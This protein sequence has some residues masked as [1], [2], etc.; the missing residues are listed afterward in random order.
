[1]T[2][3]P[4]LREYVESKLKRL[5]K[6]ETLSATD[7]CR[8][9]LRVIKKRHTVEVTIYAHGTIF[10]A[11]ESS[12]DMYASVDLVVDKLTRMIRKYK[13]RME[14]RHRVVQAA[15]RP[16]N[17]VIHPE[18]DEEQFELVRVKQ[19][20]YKPMEVDEAIMQMDLLG[21]NFFVFTNASSGEVNVVYKRNDGGY[22]LIE[23]K[24][25]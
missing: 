24:K 17:T 20:E 25:V 6:F 9:N 11:E 19:F 2:V 12:E 23:R 18:D 1:M 16:T 21:H 8:V 3:T 5:E 13:N 10:R 4:A 14:N 22:G 15:V 7:E